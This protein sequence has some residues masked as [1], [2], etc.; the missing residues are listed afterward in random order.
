M[1]KKELR[2]WRESLGLTQ[3]SLAHFLG[4]EKYAV[5]KWE[6]GKNP[7][8]SWMDIISILITREHIMPK[9]EKHDEIYAMFKKGRP[10]KEV[11]EKLGLPMGKAR[12]YLVEYGLFEMA[13]F[14]HNRKP[15]KDD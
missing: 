5:M 6:Q 3:K 10:F 4:Y 11:D 9:H 15:S 14:S 13:T 12:S 8:P 2:K 7:V 1:T